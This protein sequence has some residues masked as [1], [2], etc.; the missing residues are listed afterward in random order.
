MDGF[1]DA[2][3][4][5][6]E[7]Q[8]DFDRFFG[9]PRGT[10]SSFGSRPAFP[11][12]LPGRSARGY[13]L[14]NVSDDEGFVYVE[15]LA[16][17]LDEGQLEV[18]V[19][20]NQLTIAGEKQALPSGIQAE[21]YHRSERSAGRFVRTIEVPEAVTQDDATADYRDGM[22]RIRLKKSPESAPKRIQVSTIDG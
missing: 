9:R 3:R 8:R 17:G 21:A 18:S 6:E 20:G 4:R 2:F 7:L 15:A 19:H 10:G 13:P 16:P 22:L 12:F 5:L 1:F 14:V 11:A